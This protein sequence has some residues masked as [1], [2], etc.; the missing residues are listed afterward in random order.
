[1]SCTCPSTCDL[2]HAQYFLA[3]VLPD[4]SYCTVPNARILRLLMASVQLGHTLLFCTFL[5]LRL[6]KHVSLLVS[7]GTCLM[8]ISSWAHDVTANVLLDQQNEHRT[9]ERQT[10]ECRK[11]EVDRTE[12]RKNTIPKGHSVER[13]L[14]VLK[15]HCAEGRC[16]ERTLLKRKTSKGHCIDRTLCQKDIMSRG[17]CVES[18]PSQTDTVERT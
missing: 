17:P 7:F 3:R 1:M 9:T 10:A 2:M 8:H 14:P 11:T 5:L 15:G 4:V 16:V 18:T 12:S 6:H 13:K